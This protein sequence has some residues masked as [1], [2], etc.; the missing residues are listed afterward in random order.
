M[1]KLLI[2]IITIFTIF[3]SLN[4]NAA[5]NDIYSD[6]QKKIDEFK[7]TFA[8]QWNIL[9]KNEYEYTVSINDNIKKYSRFDRLELLDKLMK[10]IKDKND[11]LDNLD[12]YESAIYGGGDAHL[13]YDAAYAMIKKGN[14]KRSFKLFNFLINEKNPSGFTV[15]GSYYFRGVI[16]EDFYHDTDAAFD[17]YLKVHAYPACLVFTDDSYIRAAKICRFRRHRDTALALYSIRIPQIDYYKNEIRKIFASIDIARES[18]DLANRVRQVMRADEIARAKPKYEKI[19]ENLYQEL[20][21]TTDT[22]TIAKISSYLAKNEPF[23]SYTMKTI[24]KAL[25]GP[26]AATNNPALEDMLLHDW[27]LMENVAEMHPEILTN[28]VLSNNIFKQKRR[29]ILKHY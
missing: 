6:Y 11:P 5:T 26:D 8:T 22:N 20:C 24:I 1:P 7:K 18:K 13:V 17:A 12:K 14:V 29:N 16:L 4:I 3:Q 25:T 9:T 28:R 19:A 27:P 10:R 21:A 2:T 15:G 23:D